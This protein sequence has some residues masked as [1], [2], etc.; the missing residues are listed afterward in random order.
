MSGNYPTQGET[1]P[2]KLVQSI[3]DLY[4]GRNN[5]FGEFTL[6]VA[7]ATTTVVRSP[8]SGPQSI[9]LLTPLNNHAATE[10]GAG[11]LYISAR[12]LGEFTITHSSS[13]N[14]RNFGY[15]ALG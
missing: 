9:P 1:S 10:I 6:E 12:A 4:A 15:V 8:N 5:C 3:Q 13:A 7:P 14:L 2:I 11:G